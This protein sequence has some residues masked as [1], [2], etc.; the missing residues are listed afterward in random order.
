[1]KRI[2]FVFAG[3]VLILIGVI[4]LIL[5]ILPG[6]VFIFLGLSL[7]APAFAARLK[8]RVLRKF[9]KKEIVYLEHWKKLKVHAGFTTR[10]FPLVL[11]KTEDLSTG[12]NQT[13]FQKLF[14]ESRVLL[15]HGMT[16]GSKF[17]YLGQVHKD[18][19]A[20]LDD[21]HEL[22]EERFIHIPE[23]DGILT[24]LKHVTLLVFTADCLPVF[25]AAGK[26]EIQWI[27][28]VHAGW[29]GTEKKI[30][31]KALEAIR[32]RSGCSVSDIHVILGPRVGKNHYEVGEEF[33]D[34][35][36][37]SLHRKKGKLYFDLAG[38]NTRQLLEAGVLRGRIVDLEL[39]TVSENED[40][41]SSRKEKEAA[42]RM[43]SFISKF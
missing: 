1:M 9:S 37:A 26:E 20:I 40:F 36:S 25:F 10:H 35:F 34:H 39:C 8:R 43:I 21:A 17:V 2:L 32:E 23:S 42:G 41:Y 11:R 27:G 29:R 7:I 4:G 16:P 19:I 30:V 13:Q 33:T 38:E 28:L 5:P 31:K 12:P 14:F 6:W 18:R 24:N 3:I 15:A 22:K